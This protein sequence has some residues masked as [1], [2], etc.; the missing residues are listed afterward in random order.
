MPFTAIRNIRQHTG[1][2][3]LNMGMTLDVLFGAHPQRVTGHL[4][5]HELNPGPKKLSGSNI[6]RSVRNANSRTDGATSYY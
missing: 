4:T 2:I 1:H 5:V 3:L 6:E